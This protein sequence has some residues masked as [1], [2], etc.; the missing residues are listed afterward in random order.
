LAQLSNFV[1]LLFE[2]SLLLRQRFLQRLQLLADRG[3][4]VGRR[5]L[6]GA[7]GERR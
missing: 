7:H 5:C 6:S 3:D 1:S 2:H 4:G